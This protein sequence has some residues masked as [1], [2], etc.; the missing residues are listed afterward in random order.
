MGLS[1][2]DFSWKK[3]GILAGLSEKI[4]IF[5]R[6]HLLSN[7]SQRRS[8]M[9]KSSLFISIALSTFVLAMLAG[10]LTAYRTYVSSS[11][12]TGQNSPLVQTAV[13]PSSNITPQQ[14]AQVAAQF[15]GRNDLYSVATVPLN[16]ASTYK[17]TFSSESV[18]YVSMAGQVVY[19]Q[20]GSVAPSV[21]PVVNSNISVPA[22]QPAAPVIPSGEEH[23]SGDHD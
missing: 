5:S 3:I 18:V 14:A 15:L 16:G 21:A 20:T 13:Q 23:E 12:L 22:V 2:A 6:Y 10:V 1:V 17:V 8:L 7:L 11:S 19:Y 9:K 4:P